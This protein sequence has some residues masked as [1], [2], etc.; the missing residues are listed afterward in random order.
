MLTGYSPYRR[1]SLRALGDLIYFG[2]KPGA[3][4]ATSS[5]VL[6]RA[7]RWLSHTVVVSDR[8]TFEFE[9]CPLAYR[10]DG[11]GPP[12]V[13]IQGVGAYGT[14]PNPLTKILKEHYTCL[15]FDNR[16]MGASQPAGRKLTVPQMARDTLALLDHVGWDTSH[17]L[18]HSLGG[19]AAMELALL[20]KPRVRSLTLLNTF[21]R[22]AD[23][24]RMT[25]KLLWILLRLRFG[26]HRMRRNAFME[27]VI[28]PGYTGDVESAAD[29]LSAVFGHDIADMAPASNLQ[30]DAMKA[31]D[32]TGKLG[33]L[34]GIPTLVI[35]GEN[36]L[37]ARPSSGRAIAEEIH[38]ARYIEIP[39][40]SHSFPVMDPER[41]AALVVEHIDEAER[42]RKA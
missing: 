20:A 24:S 21:G 15:S 29:Q 35:S 16:G 17:V 22:G 5:G 9:G 33:K 26:P 3:Y 34:S 14:S 40:A 32:V 28:P 2:L 13:M 31:H 19:L 27:L 23:A 1:S 38:G 42:R 37:I 39:R 10:L 8:Q 25:L 18:G 11:A 12:L 7:D 36:D 6:P 4:S 41:C 30:L